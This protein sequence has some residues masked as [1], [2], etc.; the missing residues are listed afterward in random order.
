[1]IKQQ[2]DLSG[3]CIERTDSETWMHTLLKSHLMQL[4]NS[5]LCKHF[6][7]LFFNLKLSFCVL[8]DAHYSFIRGS[9]SKFSVSDFPVWM[10]YTL[11][12]FLFG[13]RMK[14]YCVRKDIMNI[15]MLQSVFLIIIILRHLQKALLKYFKSKTLFMNCGKELHFSPR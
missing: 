10:A 6:F 8:S 4:G 11:S 9:N 12:S 14:Q 3:S 13:M 1:M 2:R 15:S 5:A 7:T